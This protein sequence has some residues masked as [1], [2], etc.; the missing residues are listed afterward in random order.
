MADIRFPGD[1]PIHAGERRAQA[2]L[3][4]LDQVMRSVEQ[5]QMF[6]CRFMG[7]TDGILAVSGIGVNSGVVEEISPTPNMQVKIN[8]TWGFVHDLP[9]FAGENVVGALA[10][11]VSNPRI[12]TVSIIHPD[13]ADTL[14]TVDP[15]TEIFAVNEREVYVIRIGNEDTTPVAPSIGDNELKLAEIYHRVGETSIKNTDDA[16]NGYITDFRVKKNF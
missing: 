14:A 15:A 6:I 4:W 13:D 8:E 9:L 11:P 5:M 12:D 1:A 16:T 7:G 2:H 10:A 3:D